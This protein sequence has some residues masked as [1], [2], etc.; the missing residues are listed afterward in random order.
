MLI[1]G[2]KKNFN[3]V[4]AV[5]VCF[6]RKKYQKIIMIV[7]YLNQLF[8]KKTKISNNNNNNNNNNNSNISKP[9]VFLKKKN[10]K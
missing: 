10:L 6:L 3:F 5:F 7:I 1:Y 2:E 9:I 4:F 8:F